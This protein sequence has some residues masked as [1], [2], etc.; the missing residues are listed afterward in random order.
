MLWGS[1][2]WWPAWHTGWRDAM[3]GLLALCVLSST[4]AERALLSHMGSS[5]NALT[6]VDQRVCCPGVCGTC[7]GNECESRPGGAHFCCVDKLL[8]SAPPCGPMD[9]GPCVLPKPIP[10]GKKRCNSGFQDDLAY[11][12]CDSSCVELL[13]AE[14]VIGGS[15][16]KRPRGCERCMCKTCPVC[17]PSP[18]PSPPPNYFTRFSTEPDDLGC[19]FEVTIDKAWSHGFSAHV[20]PSQWVP[21][22][23]VLLDYGPVQVEI[24]RAWGANVMRVPKSNA[25]IFTLSGRQDEKGGFA[26]NGGTN[27]VGPVPTILC[28]SAP[29]PPAAK[30]PPPPPPPPPPPSPPLPPP[31]PPPPVSDLAPLPPARTV[32]MSVSCGSVAL[33]WEPAVTR[34]GQPLTGYQISAARLDGAGEPI[35]R[36]VDPRTHIMEIT[37]L[38]SGTR[39]SLIV[40]GRSS[41]GLGLASDPLVVETGP[42][43]AIPEA[44]FDVPQLDPATTDQCDAIDLILPALRPGCAGDS[45]FK[46]LASSGDEWVTVRESV[47]ASKLRLTSLNVYAAHRFRLIAV[48]AAG[49]SNPSRSSIALLTDAGHSSLTAPPEVQPTSSASFR[50]SWAVSPCRPQLVWEVLYSHHADRASGEQRAWHTVE[51][52]VSGGSIEIANL[53]CPRGCAFRVRPLSL[54]GWEQYSDPSAE[55]RSPSLPMIPEGAV[56]IELAM[57][58]P[59]SGLAR[60][61]QPQGGDL[62]DALGGYASS[63]FGAHTVDPEA[64]S[65]LSRALSAILRIDH[66]RF[67]IVEARGAGRF[68]IVDILAPRMGDRQRQRPE[69]IAM[70]LAL[71]RPVLPHLGV[72]PTGLSAVMLLTPDGSVVA[73]GVKSAEPLATQA[74]KVTIA[75]CA[76]SGSLFFVVLVIRKCA[77]S[78]TQRGRGRHARIRST[79]QH[80][81]KRR[82]TRVAAKVDDSE[83]DEDELSDVS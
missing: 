71:K 18:P 80:R 74:F 35:I 16:R 13:Q 65:E 43:A 50:V 51:A 59:V 4:A 48:N 42:A 14:P 28:V 1:G 75:I 5:C 26:F 54:K 17:M 61:S 58:P 29:P 12:E 69:A 38:V 27:V 19:R 63:G 31:P 57:D 15:S 45:S 39:Y 21:G 22:Q 60:I 70:E 36:D 2:R 77:A 7:G 53:R 47:V 49:E 56:R 11:E 44:P 24:G 66:S 67:V 34:E 79:E 83:D 30:H 78:A 46:V 3:L 68:A 55:V 25:Y 33:K 40:R 32:T 41:I 10:S 82:A 62:A 73:L 72:Q 8:E 9:T 20:R 37:G 76:V 52:S 64:A 81:G 23:R 6:S